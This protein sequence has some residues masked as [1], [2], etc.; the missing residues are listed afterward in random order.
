[1]LDWHKLPWQRFTQ[2]LAQDKTPHAILVS[3]PPGV[4][5]HAFAQAMAARLLCES[6]SESLAC[7][8][9]R[10]CRLRLAGSH[11]DYRSIQPEEGGSGIIR[12]DAI[13]ELAEFTHLSSQYE[14][15]RVVLLHPA[16]AMNRHT[17]NAL[18]KTLEEPPPQVVLILVS[19]AMEKLPATIRS[20]CQILPIHPP[21]PDVAIQWLQEQGV[22]SPQGALHLG[23][24]APLAALS[25]A[26]NQGDAKYLE[27][28]AAV[29][30]I[31]QAKASAV[32]VAESWRDWGA[33]ETA[34]LMQRLVADLR[35]A[36]VGF[37]SPGLPTA[38]LKVLASRFSP[39]QLHRLM[40][41]LIEL[42]A[43]AA[44]PL[45]KELSVEACFLV[46][47]KEGAC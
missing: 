47:T 17:A 22:E 28:G 2:Q 7:N 11:P 4:G 3:G 36:Q 46:W 34:V 32:E 16:E 33:A 41:Q 44:Q 18:L 13:R 1:M 35:H 8:V 21:A 23:G 12:I 5:K 26:E 27:L 19:H 20:R 9:C 45:S 29:S 40:D 25:I 10:G 38:A 39:I 31:T 37:V 6:R 42:R 15:S 43:A 24:G 14:G 30:D